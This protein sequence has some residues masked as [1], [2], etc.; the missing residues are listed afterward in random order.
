MNLQRG[1]RP[2]RS[3]TIFDH[4]QKFQFE[5]VSICEYIQ[6]WRRWLVASVSKKLVGLDQFPYADFVNGTSQ[7]F[8]H[9]WLN[10]RSKKPVAFRGEFQYHAC[11]NR[12]HGFRYVDN[13]D[14]LRAGDS[15]VISLPFSDYG[16]VHPAWNEILDRCDCL[17]VPV[18]IDLAYWGVSH[19]VQL[20][21]QDRHCVQQVTCSLSKAFWPLENHRVG[22]RFC[23][24]YNNDG[25]NMINEVNM[26]NHYSMGLGRHFMLSFDSDWI[27]QQ[28]GAAQISA[29]LELDL[30]AT[31][32]VIFGLGGHEYHNHN[33]GIVGNN[34]VCIS[35]LLHDL[36]EEK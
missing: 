14:D 26:Q 27:S 3:K 25:I 33:R 23:R 5:P 30:V 1:A 15:L 2:V 20:N 28:F 7:T 12:G 18:C 21:V 31:D 9:F 10:H 13:P 35:E 32:T 24:H 36:E 29:C 17:G 34:R 11:I 8:D 19:N 22:V 6:C 16:Q 4:Y